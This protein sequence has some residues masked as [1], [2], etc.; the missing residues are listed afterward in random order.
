MYQ[1]KRKSC[2]SEIDHIA[3]TERVKLIPFDSKV[4]QR[5]T[6]SL[7]SGSARPLSNSEWLDKVQLHF[8]TGSIESSRAKQAIYSL[9]RRYLNDDINTVYPRAREILLRE[10]VVIGEAPRRNQQ[11]VNEVPSVNNNQI[12]NSQNDVVDAQIQNNNENRENVLNQ[13]LVEA[14]TYEDFLASVNGNNIAKS[15]YKGEANNAEAIFE[16]QQELDEL[17][18]E[19]KIKNQ[20]MKHARTAGFEFEFGTLYGN[21]VPAS[22]TEMAV[23]QETKAYGLPYKLE[24]DA[25]NAIELVT[26]PFLYEN[27]EG[28]INSAGIK[29]DKG[30]IVTYTRNL[31]PANKGEKTVEGLQT[32]LATSHAGKGWQFLKD[33][34]RNVKVNAGNKKH[35]DGVATHINLALTAKESAAILERIRGEDTGKDGVLRKYIVRSIKEKPA[36]KALESDERRKIEPAIL[37]LSRSLAQLD[38][39][40]SIDAKQKIPKKGNGAFGRLV[41][42]RHSN[43]KDRDRLWV[44]DNPVAILK[45]ALY[46]I[47]KKLGEALADSITIEI[48]AKIKEIMRDE[49]IRLQR[50]IWKQHRKNITLSS[51][52]YDSEVDSVL[53]RLKGVARTGGGTVRDTNKSVKFLEEGTSKR[54]VNLG[55]RRDTYLNGAGSLESGEEL[56]VTELRGGT[57]VD[58]LSALD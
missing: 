51:K 15:A 25:S 53:V 40:P 17:V 57:S 38:A 44:K 48:N 30:K 14:S 26:P 43:V 41:G 20:L 7:T 35:N 34:Y 36:Y 6:V 5:V 37:H 47:E 21:D 19:H 24:M 31:R 1:A 29:A 13:Q 22:H 32:D 54:G 56:H 10:N 8:H 4:M 2:S 58:A 12:I 42:S 55:V 39:R 28:K 27:K 49:A 11:Q 46:G 52:S 3:K 33:A 50:E 16:G 23:S 9:N 18:D 45:G